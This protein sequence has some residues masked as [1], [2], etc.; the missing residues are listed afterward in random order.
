[1]AR[2]TDDAV[3]GRRHVAR[4][5]ILKGI[6]G[7]GLGGLAGCISAV[8][9]IEPDGAI[10]ELIYRGFEEEGVEPPIEVTITV[11][12]NNPDRVDWAQL[13][14]ADL[15]GTDLFEV[16]V[17]EYEWGQYMEYINSVGADPDENPLVCLGVAAGWDPHSYV[18]ML[19]H[20][21][22]HAPDGLNIYHYEN[23]TVDE[24]I[25]DGRAEQNVEERVAIYETLQE[26]LLEEAPVA[27]IQFDEQIAAWNTDTVSGFETH[28]LAVNRFKGVFAPHADVCAELDG[29]RTELIVDAEADISNTDPVSINGT[30]SYSMADLLYEQLIEFDFEGTPQPQLATD[31]E[32]LDETTWRFELR[33]GVQFH[34]EAAG[35]FT[36]S[37]VRSSFERHEGTVRA[38]DVYDWYAGMEIIDD[39][40][41]EIELTQAYMPFEAAVASVFIVPAA[42]ADPEPGE[43]DDDDG[44]DLSENPVGTGPYQFA[45]HQEGDRWRVHRFDDHW[46]TGD[47]YD[48]GVPATPPI[49]TVTFEI[50]TEGSSRHNALKSGDIDLSVG[51]P[52]ESVGE[53]EANDGFSVD[54]RISSF[55]EFVCFPLGR[56]PFNNPKV[57]QGI[58]SLIDRDR[59]LEDVFDNVG[60][61][62]LTSISPMRET[63]ASDEFRARL[64]NEYLL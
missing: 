30:I 45:E 52:A 4:R 16:D 13:L 11:N 54:R 1:M 44:I 27:Y 9:E 28:P 55:R 60:E 15:E 25:E 7:A 47:E 41:I 19:F 38:A 53:F 14:A 34:D 24:L 26:I 56:K 8:D 23:E 18:N 58:N 51:L 42:A 31:W 32:Q 37:D 35:E 64:E 3:D 39:Y 46:Y 59:L 40:E 2:G 20:S 21:A 43:G 17:E 63:Y 61:P 22:Y 49:E 50:L 6:G 57:R 29:D 33:E 12:T 36:A 62:A 5:P 48:T 10:E